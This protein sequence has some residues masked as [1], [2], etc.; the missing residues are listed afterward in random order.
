MVASAFVAS[1]VVGLGD[2]A[3]IL[4]ELVFAGL[5]IVI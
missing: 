2:V 1:D 3:A 5:I 4:V